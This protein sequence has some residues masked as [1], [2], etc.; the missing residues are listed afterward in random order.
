MRKAS[1]KTVSCELNTLHSLCVAAFSL[2]FRFWSRALLHS[3]AKWQNEKEQQQKIIKVKCAQCRKAA[4]ATATAATH[5]QQQFYNIQI[6]FLLAFFSN[7]YLINIVFFTLVVLLF[8]CL[9]CTFHLACRISAC[10]CVFHFYCAS[11]CYA[12]LLVFFFFRLAC[13][14]AVT[15]T[16]LHTRY[17]L[18]KVKIQLNSSLYFRVSRSLT[19]SLSLSRFAKRERVY[20][21]PMPHM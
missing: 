14:L 19:F 15:T 9:Y 11:S 16:V 18:K 4:M 7:E 12:L 17:L 6:F 10:A 3:R 21:M 8:V 5:Q 1:N 20:E 2:S 13:R